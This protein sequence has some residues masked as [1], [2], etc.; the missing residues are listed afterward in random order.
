MG[1]DGQGR[2][3]QKPDYANPELARILIFFVRCFVY[4]VCPSALI[5]V[6]NTFNSLQQQQQQQ[7]QQQL[8]LFALP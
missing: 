7:Q 4:I 3:V 6:G 1:F 8:A 2:V 5:L